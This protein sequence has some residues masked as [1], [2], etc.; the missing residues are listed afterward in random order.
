MKTFYDLKFESNDGDEIAYELFPNHYG[1][2]VVRGPYSEG[3]RMGLYEIAVIK[4]TPDMER[5]EICYDTPVTN[6]VIGHLKPEY[7]TEYMIQ[8]QKL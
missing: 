6:D 1:I 8:I 5:S 3:G 2:S 4:M 7:V